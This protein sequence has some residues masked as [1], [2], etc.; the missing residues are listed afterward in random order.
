MHTEQSKV[1]ITHDVFQRGTSGHSAGMFAWH[2]LQMGAAHWVVAGRQKEEGLI[3]LAPFH[4][5]VSIG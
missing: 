4:L 2:V 5:L 3:C 1:A